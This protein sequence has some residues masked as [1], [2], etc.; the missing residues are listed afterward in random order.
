MLDSW[1]A[2]VTNQ[3]NRLISKELSRST[4]C[5][6]PCHVRRKGGARGGRPSPRARN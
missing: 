2:V 5:C 3:R 1:R 6:A 4:L